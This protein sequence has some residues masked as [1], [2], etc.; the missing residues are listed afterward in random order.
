MS[1]SG[2]VAAC[3]S[4]GNSCLPPDSKKC[5]EYATR[6]HAKTPRGDFAFQ[7]AGL[8]QFYFAQGRNCPLNLAF[9]SEIRC[10]YRSYDVPLLFNDDITRSGKV[11][12]GIVGVDL[13]VL[14]NQ[15]S[16]AVRTGRRQR[17]AGHF[18]VLAA[19]CAGNDLFA[20]GAADSAGDPCC[21][22]HMS[23]SRDTRKQ[24]KFPMSASTLRLPYAY[25][26]GQ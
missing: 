24:A 14:K 16:M 25:C 15:S 4:R 12:D 2:I 21:D 3:R 20:L 19:V 26:I 9:Y 11:T 22:G 10:F 8:S 18:D 13:E 7:V 5:V 17:P 1:N 6:F 23:E